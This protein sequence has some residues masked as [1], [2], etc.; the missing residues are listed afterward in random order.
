MNVSFIV[1]MD[2]QRGIGFEND[3]PWRLPADMAYFMKTTSGHTVVM[4]RRT[5]QSMGNKPLPNRNNVIIT[6]NPDFQAEGCTVIHS[7]EE[8]NHYFAGVDVFVIG[9]ADVF[10]L[11]MPMA[12]RMYITLIESEFTADTFFPEFDDEEWEI[13][14]SRQGVKDEKNPY[15]Y[16]F[17]IYERVKE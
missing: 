10:Q 15:D 7:V 13:V 9:G 17:L 1:A 16:S 12:Q 6:R 4:G 8:A 2:L 11:F 5:F 3:L 14:S